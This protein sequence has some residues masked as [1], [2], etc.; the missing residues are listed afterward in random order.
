MQV[1]STSG[2]VVQ[3][4]FALHRIEV[5]QR[6]E[7]G[8]QVFYTDEEDVD[9]GVVFSD[10]D[11]DSGD[12]FV[13]SSVA[14]EGE[15]L[16]GSF[17]DIS[18]AGT[19]LFAL[20]KHRLDVFDLS[21][22]DEAGRPS[23]VCFFQLE[24]GEDNPKSHFSTVAAKKLIPR[25]TYLVALSEWSSKGDVTHVF[26]YSA[27]SLRKIEASVFH[28]N[29][30]VRV[31][32]FGVEYLCILWATLKEISELRGPF[33]VKKVSFGGERFILNF[34]P[35]VNGFLCLVETDEEFRTMFYP[36]GEEPPVQVL[37]H[38]LDTLSGAIGLL[39]KVRGLT[40]TDVE[41]YVDEDTLHQDTRVS[42]HRLAWWE[43]VARAIHRRVGDLEHSP[44]EEELK[45]KRR[46]GR[47]GGGEGEGGGGSGAAAAVAAEYVSDRENW[48]ASF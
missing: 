33:E 23:L 3:V 12:I 47:D 34:L 21:Y 39:P 26:Q 17:S 38:P 16:E 36:H 8:R 14:P 35:C 18:V 44:A 11:F 5:Y 27:S 2:R 9:V 43:A 20:R 15:L 4:P 10:F 42:E 40:F 30:H 7:S 1:I 41:A 31:M 22:L 25:D 19:L 32:R 29:R 48:W 46:R 28:P 37:Q 45:R 6:L 13:F 24:S